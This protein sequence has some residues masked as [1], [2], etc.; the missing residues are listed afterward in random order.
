MLTPHHG[1]YGLGTSPF[2]SSSKQNLVEE[3]VSLWLMYLSLSLSF[4]VVI[5]VVHFMY[6][7][8]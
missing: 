3:E 7:M 8:C 1:M 5:T 2:I 6:F 4:V